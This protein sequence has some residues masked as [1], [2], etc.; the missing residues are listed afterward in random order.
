MNKTSPGKL[1]SEIFQDFLLQQQIVDYRARARAGA[2]ILTSWSRV[3]MKRLPNTAHNLLFN[4]ILPFFHDV[5]CLKN[6][7]RSRPDLN[8]QL[9]LR[10]VPVPVPPYQYI[11]F[12]SGLGS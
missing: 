1:R 4:I 7:V 9:W 2:A 12:G 8:L 11:V 3:K 5:S 10:P 6:D